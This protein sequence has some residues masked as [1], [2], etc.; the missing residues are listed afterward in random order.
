LLVLVFTRTLLADN[1][2]RR[3]LIRDITSVEGVRDN[4]LVGYGL[5]VGLNRTGDSQQT[6]FT[7]QTL[8]NAMQK[9]GV[10]ISPAQVE[11]KNVASVFITASL[12]PFAR[13]GAKLDAGALLAHCAS[14]LPAFKAPKRI[15]L[16]ASL[17]KTDRGKLD[18]K[19]L[20]ERWRQEAGG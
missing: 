18:R 15:V 5:V 16:S 14:V 8:A 9:M 17:P 12:P 1:P 20:T 7:V 11:V 3:V 4:M 2:N 6:Y 10:L 19:A 13:P